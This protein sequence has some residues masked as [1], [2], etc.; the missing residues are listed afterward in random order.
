MVYRA[1]HNELKYAEYSQPEKITEDL[2]FRVFT[3]NWP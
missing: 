2:A 1:K 3:R